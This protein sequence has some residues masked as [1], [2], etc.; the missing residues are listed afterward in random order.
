MKDEQLISNIWDGLKKP[1]LKL[2]SD[3]EDII[4]PIETTNQGGF[5]DMSEYTSKDYIDTQFRFYEKSIDSRIDR[6]EKGFQEIKEEIQEIKR[7]N[8]NTKTTVV[9]TAVTSTL[10]IVGILLSMQGNSLSYFTAGKA[11]KEEVK[12]ETSQVL[13]EFQDTLQSI[14]KRLEVIE[15]RGNQ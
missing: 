3:Y 10:A 11:F 5:R 13:K 9:V 1:E 14:N 4:K 6:I 15:N 8:K 2:V 12:V 7:D